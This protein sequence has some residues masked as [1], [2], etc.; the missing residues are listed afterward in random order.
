[1]AQELD[2]E[3]K[4]LSNKSLQDVLCEMLNAFQQDEK[5]TF[6]KSILVETIKKVMKHDLTLKINNLIDGRM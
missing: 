6:S 5:L 2:L 4:R 3:I 1:M